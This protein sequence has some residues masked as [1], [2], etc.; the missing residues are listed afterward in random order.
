[1]D[2][3]LTEALPH[4]WMT[5]LGAALKEIAH[6]DPTCAWAKQPMVWRVPNE[7]LRAKWQGSP[8]AP[9]MAAQPGPLSHFMG[10]QPQIL[11]TGSVT[12]CFNFGTRGYV[13]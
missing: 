1:M 6:E 3:F 2:R 12:V 9:A 8:W 7:E 4:A 11:A 13:A 10:L 5:S